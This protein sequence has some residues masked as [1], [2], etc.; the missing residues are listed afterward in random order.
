M[1][2]WEVTYPYLFSLI[3]GISVVIFKWDISDVENFTSILNSA[4]TVS[5]IVIAFLATM[6]SIL[7]TLTNADVMKRINKGDAEGLLVSYI[8]STIIA[9]L[10][11]AVYS[12]I[13]Y[14]FLDLS[15]LVSRILLA[16]FV[17]LLGFFILSSYRIIHI[18][19]NILGEILKE[20]KPQSQKKNI[21]TPR[22]NSGKGDLK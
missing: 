15:G 17:A 16:F 14:I 8:K 19:S 1:R 18:V 10:L 4:V 2:K 11:L 12:M 9:G 21:F 3:T 7:I 22:I 6:L 20:N 5:S 13:L